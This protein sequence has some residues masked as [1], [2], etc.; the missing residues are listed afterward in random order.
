MITSKMTWA[1]S[2]VGW[3]LGHRALCQLRALVVSNSF[4]VHCR[5]MLLH[6]GWKSFPEL[7]HCG[8]EQ[9]RE[10]LNTGQND[11]GNFLVSLIPAL[12]DG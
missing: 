1:C 2:L 4:S 10:L 9:Y 7:A 11:I 12:P 3:S 6:S 5:Y 8:L